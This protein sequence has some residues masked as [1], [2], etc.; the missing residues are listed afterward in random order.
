[1]SLFTNR[2]VSRAAQPAAHR[3]C[4]PSSSC[5]PSWTALSVSSSKSAHAAC[6]HKRHWSHWTIFGSDASQVWWQIGQYSPALYTSA[7]SRHRLSIRASTPA[8]IFSFLTLLAG[9]SA[10]CV[11]AQAEHFKQSAH[12]H[13]GLFLIEAGARLSSGPPQHCR[14][15]ALPQSPHLAALLMMFKSPPPQP[16]QVCAMAPFFERDFFFGDESFRPHDAANACAMP[17]PMSA[18]AMSW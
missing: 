5:V 12:C 7:Q 15:Y 18:R 16:S 11:R 3:N 2:V 8:P 6:V 14:W 10:R 1:M 9:P 4:R 13:G 17:P